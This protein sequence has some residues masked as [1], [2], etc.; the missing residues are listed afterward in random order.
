M[1]IPLVARI[2]IMVLFREGLSHLGKG[3]EREQMLHCARHRASELK[4]PLVIIDSYSADEGGALVSGCC[5]SD[6][7]DTRSDLMNE[8]DIPV[9][10][11]SSVVLCSFSLEYMPDIRKAWKEI[12]RV[13][14]SPS[15]VFVAHAKKSL[16][17][18]RKWIIESA[19]PFSPDLRFSEMSRPYMIH[20]EE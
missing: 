15:N 13:A 2:A 3:Q 14:G 5:P 20:E 9:A 19:P 1:A 7:V 17:N 12:M 10:N 6:Q 16:F 18:R 11:D 8:G 4:R